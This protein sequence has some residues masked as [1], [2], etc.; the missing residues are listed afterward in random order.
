MIT[1]SITEGDYEKAIQTLKPILD[2]KTPFRKIDLLDSSFGSTSISRAEDF[3][4]TLDKFDLTLA[5]KYDRLYREPD[6]LIQQNMRVHKS[7]LEY[8][9]KYGILPH[10]PR[11]VKFYPEELQINKKIVEIFDLEARELQISGQDSYREWAY[12]K[13]AWAIDDLTKGFKQYLEKEE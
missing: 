6:L 13:A 5:T 10:I 3:F 9:Q 12:R 1:A 8:C 4:K 2:G 11:P 7:V